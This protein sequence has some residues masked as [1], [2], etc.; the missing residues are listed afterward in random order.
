MHFITLLTVHVYVS[1]L[2]NKWGK[3]S[4]KPPSAPSFYIVMHNIFED[5]A[6][7]LAKIYRFDQIHIIVTLHAYNVQGQ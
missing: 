4:P 6:T 3:F 1:C 7:S 5:F 2:K